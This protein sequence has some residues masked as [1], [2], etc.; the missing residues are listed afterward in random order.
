MAA[1]DLETPHRDESHNDVHEDVGQGAILFRNYKL[2]QYKMKSS[3]LRASSPTCSDIS[4]SGSGRDDSGVESISRSQRSPISEFSDLNSDKLDDIRSRSDSCGSRISSFSD[5][6]NYSRG[7]P[8]M[9]KR[10]HPEI[11]GLNRSLL[12]M[13]SLCE[14]KRFEE[15]AM[16]I[17]SEPSQGEPTSQQMRYMS[18]SMAYGNPMNGLSALGGL[19]MNSMEGLSRMAQINSFNMNNMQSN[20]GNHAGMKFIPVM[21]SMPSGLPP[22]MSPVMMQSSPNMMEG[23]SPGAFHPHSHPSMQHPSMKTPFHPNGLNIKSEFLNEPKFNSLQQESPR[24]TPPA[25][26]THTPRTKEEELEMKRRFYAN[27]NLDFH[28]IEAKCRAQIASQAEEAHNGCDSDNDEP[29][30]CGICNDKATGLHYGIIT[31]EGCKGFFKRTVQ[32]KR[33]YTCIADGNCEVTKTQRNR[34]QYCRFKKC[35]QSGMVLAAVREDRMPGG[36]NSGAVYN[37][38]KVKYK[39]HK[40]RNEAKKQRLQQLASQNGSLAHGSLPSLPSSGLASIPTSHSEE[41]M[42]PLKRMA[43]EAAAA[44]RAEFTRS[45]HGAYENRNEVYNNSNSA[46]SDSQS[47]CI[48]LSQKSSSISSSPSMRSPPPMLEVTDPNSSTSGTPSQNGSQL[49]APPPRQV[50]PSPQKQQSRYSLPPTNLSQIVGELIACE[51]EMDTSAA[52]MDFLAQNEDSLMKAMCKLGDSIVTQLVKWTKHLPFYSDIPLA[53]HTQLLTSK[54]HEILLLITSAQHALTTTD[55]QSLGDFNTYFKSNMEKLQ[56]YLNNV[57]GKAITVEELDQEVGDMMEKVS[58]VGHNFARMRLNKAEYVC[59]KVI[60]LLNQDPNPDHPSLVAI[61]DFYMAVLRDVIMQQH[62]GNTERF[63]DL[64][65][66][67]PQIQNASSLLLQSKMIYIPFL[68]NTM[69]S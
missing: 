14:R 49:E 7:E 19:N 60:L 59:L 16:K 37:L 48:D 17:K 68:L 35:L 27:Y 53:V 55:N 5:T 34:C 47:Q 46:Y 24:N 62:P 51:K 23:L 54:W 50:S 45:S 26:P 58:R 38:Y 8:P 22:M 15:F 66:Q 29:M 20:G 32:N 30:A 25:P 2:K 28:E 64:L 13:Q 43:I 56:Y 63:C 40:K 18:P 61:K 6:S 57:L 67:L 42:P 12:D 41:F 11:H 21:S 9:L 44:A 52:Q 69:K 31:C 3:Q 33:V 39:R 1:G 10:E 4:E 65:A 36:R